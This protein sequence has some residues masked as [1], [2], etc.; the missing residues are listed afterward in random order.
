MKITIGNGHPK[1]FKLKDILTEFI[2][3]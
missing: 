2:N 1:H 3:G